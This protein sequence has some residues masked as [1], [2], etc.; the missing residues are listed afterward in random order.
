MFLQT[1]NI[2]KTI[3]FFSIQK[4]IYLFSFLNKKTKKLFKFYTLIS[5]IN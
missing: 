3:P 4:I 5:Q 2:F 1:L